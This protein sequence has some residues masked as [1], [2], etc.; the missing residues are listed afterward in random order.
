MMTIM[1]T[2]MM[3]LMMTIM[4]IIDGIYERGAALSSSSP[5]HAATLKDYKVICHPLHRFHFQVTIVEH[6][7]Q[8]GEIF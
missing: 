6:T 7:S 2:L 8:Y 3:T 1:M 5:S 4:I